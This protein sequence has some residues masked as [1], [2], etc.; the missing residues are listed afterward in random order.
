MMLLLILVSIE[1]RL[2]V[3]NHTGSVWISYFKVAEKLRKGGYSGIVRLGAVCTDT[4]GRKYHAKPWKFDIEEVTS[5]REDDLF[6]DAIA[7]EERRT[8]EELER[9]AKQ[10]GERV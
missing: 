1:R 10:S 8:K 5:M 2:D 6:K 9:W 3:S 7:E 4:V